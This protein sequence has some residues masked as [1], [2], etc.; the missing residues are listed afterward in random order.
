[1]AL[2]ILLHR[3]LGAA[4]E[5]SDMPTEER[6]AR[7]GN[8]DIIQQFESL[9]L[10]DFQQE[11][12]IS[13]SNESYSYY[14]YD[15]IL[16]C[17]HDDLVLAEDVASIPAPVGRLVAGFDVGRTRDR[18]ELAV[19]EELDGV[20][21]C[22]F[23]RSYV[24]TPFAEQEAELRR[25]LN[26]L[27]IARLSIDRS[28]IGMNLAENLARDFPKSSRRTSRPKSKERWATDMKILLQKRGIQ[29]PR[30]RELVAR[31]TR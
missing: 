5:A 6:V 16:P 13:S 20:F 17:T 3:P 26:M 18:S 10:E 31:S 30:H 1:M 8:A 27:P 15:L 12:K 2:S 19:F 14:P 9:A 11:L 4:R 25:L 29:L 21:I 24:Q 23:L 28:G 7:F 22:R